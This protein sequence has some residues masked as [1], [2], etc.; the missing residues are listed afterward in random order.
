MT[1][2]RTLIGLVDAHCHVDLFPDPAALVAD[3]ERSGIHT[4]AVTNAPSVFRH[5][6]AL[7]KDCRYVHAAI[8][9]HPQL[10]RTHGRELEEFWPCLEETRFVGEIGLDNVT[11]DPKDRKAQRDIFA[12]ILERS[13]SQGGKILTIHSRRAAADVLAAI[14]AD[15]PGTTILHWFSGSATEL[16]CAVA[17]G[18]HFSV[19]PAMIHSKTGRALIAMMPKARVLTET[20]GPFVQIGSR[21]AIPNDVTGVVEHLASIWQLSWDAA[22]ET[23]EANFTRILS[24]PRR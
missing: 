12:R 17:S 11:N 14:G 24:S 19:N 6:Q 16:R 18:C 4:I 23:V 5:T 7:C 10:V 20:D 13:A 3:A 9:L 2:D 1:T 21:A 8:G 15:F 22:K